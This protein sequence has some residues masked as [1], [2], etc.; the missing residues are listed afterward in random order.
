MQTLKAVAI[1]G[2][3][4]AGSSSIYALAK[5]EQGRAQEEV[6]QRRYTELEQVSAQLKSVD[7]NLRQYA[8]A[9]ESDSAKEIALYG[10][11]K[12]ALDNVVVSLKVIHGSVLTPA[13]VS[14]SMAKVDA[15]PAY[16]SVYG[17]L[18]KLG[19]A[20]WQAS[21]GSERLDSLKAE[22]KEAQESTSAASTMSAVCS[23]AFGQDEG[24]ILLS[25]VDVGLAR[26]VVLMV[27]PAVYAN[28]SYPV[29]GRF[30]VIPK[31]VRQFTVTNA[32]GFNA[33]Q[34]NE[35]VPT[36]EV[37][38]PDVLAEQQRRIAEG[39]AKIDEEANL[40]DQAASRLHA[41]LKAYGGAGAVSKD[42][43]LPADFQVALSNFSRLCSKQNQSDD[44]AMMCKLAD[45]AVNE[46][47]AE[48]GVDEAVV[49]QEK[50]KVSAAIEKRE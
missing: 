18:S 14:E 9:P 23:Q 45:Q 39:R 5:W 21:T 27:E 40:T 34:S 26:R 29:N 44:D 33:W 2:A 28:A 12:S 30:S 3:V 1:V 47:G 50:E 10:Q 24:K 35:M 20:G 38:S 41:L 13:T 25:C 46:K 48:L 4:L 42:G 8:A 49:G 11:A 31:G 19:D 17:L 16:S 22:L 6:T 7:S 36:F 15:L 32:N 43:G 37:V